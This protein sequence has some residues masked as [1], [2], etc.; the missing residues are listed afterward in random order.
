M[1]NS[2]DI[3][4]DINCDNAAF[5]DSPEQEVARILHRVAD[6]L[7]S[8]EERLTPGMELKLFDFNGNRTGLLKAY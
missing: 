7:E 2:L 8:G 3:R 4:I 5:E 6:S 1:E